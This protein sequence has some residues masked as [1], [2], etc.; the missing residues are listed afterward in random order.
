[1]RRRRGEIKTLIRFRAEFNSGYGDVQGLALVL[2]DALVFGFRQ[3]DYYEFAQAA[4]NMGA[5]IDEHTIMAAIHRVFG[6]C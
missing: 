3:L 6:A 2:A 5:D 1:M 4:E